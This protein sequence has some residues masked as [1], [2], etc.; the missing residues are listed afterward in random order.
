VERAG[1]SAAV[2]LLLVPGTEGV[3]VLLIRRANRTGDPWSGH[4][5]LPGGF[6]SPADESLYV[7]ALRETREEVAIDLERD[8]ELLGCLS[9]VTPAVSDVT[10]RPF[11][12]ASEALPSIV[13]NHEVEAVAWTSLAAIERGDSPATFELSVG[14][15]SQRFPG[16]S[17][18]GHVVWGMTYRVLMELVERIR[19]AFGESAAERG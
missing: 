18:G 19:R 10:V 12:F 3:R 15:A 8:A 6:R 13:L 9:D 4:M 16:F 17:V 5:A 2:C 14:A 7:T 11:V 1:R